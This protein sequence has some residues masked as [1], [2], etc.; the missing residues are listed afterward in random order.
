[1]RLL[2]ATE[3]AAVAVPMHRAVAY[4]RGARVRSRGGHCCLYA[5]LA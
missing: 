2:R 1:M 4:R 5:G 3:A